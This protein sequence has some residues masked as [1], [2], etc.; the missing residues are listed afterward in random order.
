MLYGS[1]VI[2]MHKGG[3]LKKKLLAVCDKESAYASKFCEYVAKE[4]PF[5]V[6]VF[7][8]RENLEQNREKDKID[9]LLIEREEYSKQL[10][11]N[12]RAQIVILESDRESVNEQNGGVYK[13][14]SCE[15]VMKEVMGRLEIQE[16]ERPVI[17]EK[18]LN[19]IGFYSPIKR[20][21]QTSLALTMGQMLAKKHKVLYL[22]FESF[23]GLNV[24][25]GKEF[26]CDI[27]DLIYYITN[28]K[29][30]LFYK[31]QAM[32]QSVGN[33]D[34]IPPAFS[35]MD[36]NRITKEQWM[37]MIKEIEKYSAYEYILLDL[38]DNI[39]GLP[40][41]LR[42]CRK[43]FTIVKDDGMAMA[44]MEQYKLLLEKADY[45]D[46]LQKTKQCNVSLIRDLP[47]EPEQLV[48]GEL[49]DFT[50]NLIRKELYE[51]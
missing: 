45:E 51:F 30:A 8:S 24:R 6:A 10:E 40:D 5:D 47:F 21:L 27:T 39:Q 4:F 43:V 16:N 42:C 32:T 7:T 11:E 48:Y 19:L 44:K 46:V 37:M 9:I 29:E 34:F 20:G 49:A 15:T 33:M 36:I 26:M 31:L 18:G 23:S 14:Q 3:N 38:S 17:R 50:K 2:G 13:Y 12:V 41:L 22:N 28:A 35:Y 1:C 25:F